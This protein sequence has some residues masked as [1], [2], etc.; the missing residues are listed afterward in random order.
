[1]IM[2]CAARRSLVDVFSALSNAGQGDPTDR[3][4]DG[5]SPGLGPERDSACGLVLSSRGVSGYDMTP[6]ACSVGG[7]RG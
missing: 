5:R 2:T 4:E 6:R 1:M 3:E 7:K